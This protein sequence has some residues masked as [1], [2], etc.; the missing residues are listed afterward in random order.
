LS[1]NALLINWFQ[2]DIPI[3]VNN[4]IPRT[5]VDATRFCM[6][7]ILEAVY[8][9]LLIIILYITFNIS[10]LSHVPRNND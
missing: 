8:N 4:P 1:P 5:N 6:K 10:Q 3:A 7:K 2:L 9:R